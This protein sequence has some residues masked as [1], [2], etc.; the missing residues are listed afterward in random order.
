[1]FVHLCVF[2]FLFHSLFC[3]QDRVTYRIL[4]DSSRS[5]F[6]FDIDANGV[7]TLKLSV[8]QETTLVY[9]VSRNFVPINFFLFLFFFSPSPH[10]DRL[11][12]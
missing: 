9:D 10:S 11:N 6:Y 8:L 12:Q 1:M 2:Y 3:F 5:N 4:P 7:I